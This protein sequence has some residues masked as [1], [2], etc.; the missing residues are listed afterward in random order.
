MD[1]NPKNKG[2][3]TKR[4]NKLEKLRKGRNREEERQQTEIKV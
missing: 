2:K 4:A 1:K 3:N